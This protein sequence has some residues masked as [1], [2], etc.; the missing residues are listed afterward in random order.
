LPVLEVGDGVFEATTSGDTHLA[1]TTSTR[2]I[3]DY[4]AEEF[5]AEGID[6][7]KDK[8]A[9]QRLTE[10]A[11]KAKLNCLASPKRKS[12]YRLLPPPGWS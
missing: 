10:A 1:V 4:L 9:L 12:T 2:K 8:Q 3:V 5:R 6:L 11:E 7:R